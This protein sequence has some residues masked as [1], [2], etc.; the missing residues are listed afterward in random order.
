MTYKV[1]PFTASITQQEGSANA[2]AQLE[3]LI[4]QM[5][6]SGYEYVRLESI[7]TFVAGTNGCFGLGATPPTTRSISVVVFRQ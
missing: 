2:A 6:A 7:P 1:M 4:A 5:A 3:Q